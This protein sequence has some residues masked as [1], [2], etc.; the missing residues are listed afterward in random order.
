MVAIR[1]ITY[2][3]LKKFSREIAWPFKLWDRS[4]FK[5]DTNLDEFL[6]CGQIS[7]KQNNAAT[8][9]PTKLHYVCDPPC[10]I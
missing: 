4:K 7:Y 1:E 5:L 10:C 8:S 9:L 2:F 3:Y 6:F